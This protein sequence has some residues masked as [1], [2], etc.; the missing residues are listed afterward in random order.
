MLLK[1]LLAVDWQSK[2]DRDEAMR[3]FDRWAKIDYKHAIPLLSGFFSLNEEYRSLRIGE[4][5]DEETKSCFR[6][7]RDVAVFRLRRES[8]LDENGKWLG[9]IQDLKKIKEILP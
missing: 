8:G 9:E 6:I 4:P 2:L 7:I 1:F 3:L 5:M